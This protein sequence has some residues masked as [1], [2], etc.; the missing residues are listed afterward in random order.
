MGHLPNHIGTRLI[1][2]LG[3]TLHL[4]AAG[5][6]PIPNPNCISTSPGFLNHDVG[7]VHAS[8]DMSAIVVTPG[9]DWKLS[10][11]ETAIES[12]NV[13]AMDLSGLPSYPPSFRAPEGTCTPT[14]RLIPPMS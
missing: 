12:S 8:V 9:G 1:T 13:T 3:P 10:G 2:N 7:L 14:P 5:S 11:F 6:P 4:V